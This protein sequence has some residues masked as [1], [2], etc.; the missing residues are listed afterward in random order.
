MSKTFRLPWSGQSA[1]VRIE[2][3]NLFNTV[4]FGFP[5]SDIASV[6]FGRILGGATLYSPRV[7]QIVLRYRY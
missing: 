7:V 6:N 4:R 1:G 2:A 3:Y 5:T